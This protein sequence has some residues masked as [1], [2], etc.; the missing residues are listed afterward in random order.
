M[1]IISICLQIIF[2]M[3]QYGNGQEVILDKFFSSTTHVPSFRSF[4]RT[5]FTG[6]L[7]VKFFTNLEVQLVFGSCQLIYLC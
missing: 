7:L 4:D 1:M 6:G 3:D 2:K 5:L